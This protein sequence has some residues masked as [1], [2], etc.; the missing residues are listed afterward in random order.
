MSYGEWY[1][2]YKSEPKM[3]LYF[4]VL[5]VV[6]VGAFFLLRPS[7]G[8]FNNDNQAFIPVTGAGGTQRVLDGSTEMTLSTKTELSGGRT[9][10]TVLIGGW[11]ICVVD[12]TVSQLWQIVDTE[13]ARP[14]YECRLSFNKLTAGPFRP[15]QTQ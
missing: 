7:D 11:Q 9:E 1:P 14:A 15:A 3:A 12:T 4:L 10:M 13:S 8:W 5:A 2:G 6:V